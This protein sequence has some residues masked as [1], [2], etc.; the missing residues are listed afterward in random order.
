MQ[1]KSVLAVFCAMLVCVLSLIYTHSVAMHCEALHTKSVRLLIDAG[2][3]ELP[4][5]TD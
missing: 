2:H 1:I 3:A 4:N 5:T